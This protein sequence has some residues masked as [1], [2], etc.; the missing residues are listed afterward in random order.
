MRIFLCGGGSGKKIKK[1][2]IKFGSII[3]RTKPLLYIPLAMK[4][5]RY[6]SCLEWIKEEMNIIDITNIDMV[7]SGED[8]Y[9]KNFDNYSA[10][11]IGGGN[12]YKLLK[13]IKENNCFDK[14]KKY[15]DNDGIV[16]GGSAG[17]IIFG[18]D[19]DTC[20]YEDDNSIIDLK[21]TKGF[22]ALSEYSLL[23]HYNDNIIKTKDNINYLKEYSIG[24]KVLYLP[25]ED[26]IFVN[27][28]DIELIG[29]KEYI[30]F[31]NGNM[32]TA[33]PGKNLI[34]KIY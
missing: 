3:D 30:L 32:I 31:D 12:T 29:D 1:A 19:I 10:I 33:K 26:T 20:K 21:D 5:E 22:N 16:F 13:D 15:I 27:G 28:N 23:C 14:I 24:K 17:A 9:K 7:I 8:L 34:N 6:D 2:T 11:Y 18:K 4:S 25:E